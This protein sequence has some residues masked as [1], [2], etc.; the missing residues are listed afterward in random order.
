MKAYTNK[1]TA[2]VHGHIMKDRTHQAYLN[3]CIKGWLQARDVYDGKL[4]RWQKFDF[5]TY[6][7]YEIKDYVTFNEPNYL[8][9]EELARVNWRNVAAHVVDDYL[10]GEHGMGAD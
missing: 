3:Y 10:A 2:T 8:T 4:S 5:T 6:V 7:S 9:E 1:P